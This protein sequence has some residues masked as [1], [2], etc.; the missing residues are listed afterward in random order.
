MTRTTPDEH[1][2][3]HVHGRVQGVFFRQST[4]EQARR[5]GLT[6]YVQNNEDGTVTI[7]A[8]GSVPAL[9]DLESWCRQGPPAARVDRVEVSTGPV[10]G[11]LAFD[12]RR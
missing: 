8:E 7:E 5:L 10:Q 3:F 2:T 6:G 1:R 11:C 9:D 12:V 4:R